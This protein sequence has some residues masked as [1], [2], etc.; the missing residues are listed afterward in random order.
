MRTIEQLL[1]ESKVVAVIGL[2]PNPAR[3]SNRVAQYLKAQGYRV[4]P[5]NPNAEEVLGERCYPSLADVPVKI[6]LVDIFRRSEDVPPIVDEAIAAGA[7]VIWMQLGIVH[8]E[9]AQK[10][11]DAGLDVIMDKCTMVEHGQLRNQ[12]KL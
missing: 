6:D 1:K 2:S 5:V 10:A 9:A 11:A 4:I 3:D 12:G 8:K 7:K